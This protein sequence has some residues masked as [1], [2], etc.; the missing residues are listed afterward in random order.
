MANGEILGR[1]DANALFADAD[2][3]RRASVAPPQVIELS[4]VLAREVSSRFAGIS[5]VSD[6]VDV[7]EEMVRRG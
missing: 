7:T 4:G 5:E 1:G 6:I 3:M 2:L